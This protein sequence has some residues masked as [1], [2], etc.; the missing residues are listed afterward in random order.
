MTLRHCVA[1]ERSS[2]LIRRAASPPMAFTSSYIAIA[3][4]APIGVISSSDGASPSSLPVSSSS[5][6]FS[7]SHSF[8]AK[9]ASLAHVCSLAVE[10]LA[11][12]QCNASADR[13]L[14]ILLVSSAPDTRSIEGDMSS[15]RAEPRGPSPVPSMPSTAVL[16]GSNTGSMSAHLTS[17]LPPLAR[18][19][20]NFAP[21]NLCRA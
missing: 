21:R 15:L 18:I 17:M 12:S 11:A 9:S 3:S 7:P 10:A 16:Y 19:R 5:S 14:A 8:C 6:S 20:Q 2:G 4:L 1:R 13:Q